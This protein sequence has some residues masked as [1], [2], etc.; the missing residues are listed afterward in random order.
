MLSAAKVH[1][2]PENLF[3]NKMEVSKIFIK[4][5]KEKVFC[6]ICMYIST[7]G[8]IGHIE[9]KV[10][11]IIC[12]FPSLQI[13]FP[14]GKLS[15]MIYGGLASLIFCGYI[16]YD[17]DNLIKRFSYDQY[18]WAAVSLY[19]DIINLFLSLLTIFRAASS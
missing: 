8:L 11:D 10:S 19:L 6:L 18:I 16:I 1:I 9:A 17:T 7:I 3:Q 4:A 15:L 13:L 5:Q 12:Y 2:I 14:L